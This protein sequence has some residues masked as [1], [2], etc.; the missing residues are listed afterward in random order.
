M[1]PIKKK[2]NVDKLVE[3]SQ[4]NLTRASFNIPVIDERVA[5]RT[6]AYYSMRDGWDT[7]LYTGSNINNVGKWGIR[8]KWRFD[9]TDEL[10]IVVAGDYG[11]QTSE[12]CV[13]DILTYE[14]DSLLWRGNNPPTPPPAFPDRNTNPNFD[15]LAGYQNLVPGGDANGAEVLTL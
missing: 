3:F 14:G 6:A 4:Q 2:H 11:H 15:K 7:N 10:K 9:P 13:P 1:A 5:T 12:C 8:N